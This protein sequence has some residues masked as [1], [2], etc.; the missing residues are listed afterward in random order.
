M[1]IGEKDIQTVAETDQT[2]SLGCS[3]INS[4]F[5]HFVIAAVMKHDR[6]GHRGKRRVMVQE[7]HAVDRM[8]PTR[9]CFKLDHPRNFFRFVSAD[10]MQK[11]KAVQIPPGFSLNPRGFQQLV[12]IGS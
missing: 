9:F 7:K 8:I 11:N 4:R 10:I 2:G 12:G 5:Q 3:A 1:T 6:V